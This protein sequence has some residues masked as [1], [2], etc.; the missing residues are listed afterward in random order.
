MLMCIRC[1]QIQTLKVRQ[2]LT[3]K[4]IKEKELLVLRLRSPPLMF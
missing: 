4:V 2:R 3:D 1:V